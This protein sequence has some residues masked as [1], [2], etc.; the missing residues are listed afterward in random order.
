MYIHINDV[1]VTLNNK[2]ILDGITCSIGENEQWAI[3]GSNGSGKTTLA[4]A[5]ANKIFYRGEIKFS[6]T[7]NIHLAL[8]EQHHKFKNKQNIEQF[9][10]QQRFNSAD[11][12][13]T[14]TVAEILYQHNNQKLDYWI[15]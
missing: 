3:I 5:L 12:E 7:E 6:P 2:K 9:Y 15:H 10:H 11:A 14:L 1:S 4:H 8:I 13:D